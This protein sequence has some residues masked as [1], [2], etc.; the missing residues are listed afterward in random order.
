MKRDRSQSSK[1]KLK[2]KDK[3]IKK[4]LK[5]EYLINP[6]FW[7]DNFNMPQKDKITKKQKFEIKSVRSSSSSSSSSSS[8]S[9]HKSKSSHKSTSQRS[10]S[11]YDKYGDMSNSAHK[12]N[13]VGF[14]L[15]N[16]NNQSP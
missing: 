2:K 12:R 1:E 13:H 14:N 6:K 5:K 15:Q 7:Y 3:K 10:Q 16:H 11:P 9:S 8:N 4:E